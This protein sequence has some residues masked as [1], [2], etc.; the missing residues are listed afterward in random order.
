ML[1]PETSAL[2]SSTTAP[3]DTLEEL[4]GLAGM[5]IVE[6]VE[7]LRQS[8]MMLGSSRAILVQ[9]TREGRTEVKPYER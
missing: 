2:Q 3:Q 6:G 9:I 7:L 5:A 1:V 4:G 8:S